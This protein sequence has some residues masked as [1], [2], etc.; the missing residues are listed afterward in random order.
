MDE[1]LALQRQ[2]NDLLESNRLDW[3]ALANQP[4]AP[5]HRAAMRDAIKTRDLLSLSALGFG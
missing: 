1:F 4:L 3:D 5:E 2:I